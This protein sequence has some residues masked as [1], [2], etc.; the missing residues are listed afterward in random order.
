MYVI[1]RP[2]H[3]RIEID[4]EDFSTIMIHNNHKI[5]R[6]TMK[7]AASKSQPSRVDALFLAISALVI[8][9]AIQPWVAWSPGDPNYRGLNLFSYFTVQSNLIAAAVFAMGSY[10]IFTRK[11]LGEWFGTLRG[12][13]VLYMAVTAIVYALLLKNATNAN[14]AL[15]FDWK[16]FILHEFMPF[17]IVVEWLV[18]PP[19]ESVT[20]KKAFVWL[21][22]PVAWLAYTLYRAQI[23]HWYPYPFL[24][25]S[26]VGSKLGVLAYL[27]GISIAF[28]ALAQGFAWISRIRQTN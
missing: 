6:Y 11:R 19:H 18:W 1:I 16:N 9:I 4:N 13:A 20:A 12:A 28:V 22:F 5:K 25:P 3:V 14:T 23:V 15:A 21:L 10:A 7:Q 24:D 2:T 17:I 27:V 26:K 8:I